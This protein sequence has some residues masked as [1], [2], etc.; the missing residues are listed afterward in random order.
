M[1]RRSFACPD[2]YKWVANRLVPINPDEKK[3][4]PRK[5][6]DCPDGY[7]WVANR[8]VPVNHDE[9]KQGEVQRPTEVGKDSKD[10]KETFVKRVPTTETR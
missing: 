8:L 5:T 3:Y 2:G 10:N 4:T 7:K 6:W 1:A 9:N